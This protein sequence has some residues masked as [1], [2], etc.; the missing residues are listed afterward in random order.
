VKTL[1]YDVPEEELEEFKMF[2][3]NVK[4]THAAIASSKDYA[5]REMWKNSLVTANLDHN[6]ELQRLFRTYADLEELEG[7]LVLS[8]YVE[9]MMRKIVVK[10]EEDESELQKAHTKKTTTQAV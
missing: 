5:E 10:I 8:V 9:T 4:A 2:M 7:Q 3:H 6:E 1:F